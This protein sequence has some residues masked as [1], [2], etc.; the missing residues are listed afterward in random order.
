MFVYYII[1]NT[2]IMFV[3]LAGMYRDES[4]CDT[5]IHGRAGKLRH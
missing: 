1:Y 4:W 5:K 2:L 3:L